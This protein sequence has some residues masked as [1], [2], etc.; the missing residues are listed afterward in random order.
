MPTSPSSGFALRRVV[1]PA[2]DDRALLARG[3]WTATATAD[4]QLFVVGVVLGDDRAVVAE[5]P[6]RRSEPVVQLNL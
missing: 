1:D 5:L 3:D 4:R 2:H 6:E